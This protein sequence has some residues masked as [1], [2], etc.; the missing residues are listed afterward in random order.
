VLEAGHAIVF[1]GAGREHDDRHMGYVGPRSQD[2]TD[3]EP[4][5]HRQV[6]IEDDQIGRLFGHCR[7]RG[8][9]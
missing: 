8:I 6:Q 4:A 5:D 7:Q 9:A 2:A 1:A 3:V